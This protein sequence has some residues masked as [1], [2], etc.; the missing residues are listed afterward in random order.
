MSDWDEAGRYGWDVIQALYDADQVEEAFEAARE[1]EF[2][3]WAAYLSFYRQ[4]EAEYLTRRRA[5]IEEL[6]P[7]LSLEWIPE[8]VGD[9]IGRVRELCLYAC[10]RVAERLGWS[11]EEPARIAI[12]ARETDVPW[13]AHPYGYC[14]EKDPYEKICLPLN[15]VFDLQEF[16]HAVA[17]EYAHVIS[18]NLS[19]E[20]APRWLEEAVSVLA[21]RK[22]DA[23]VLAAFKAGR[24][25]WLGPEQLEVAIH[26]DNE[27]RQGLWRAYQQAGLIGRYLASLGEERRLGDLLRAHADENPWRHLGRVLRGRS[28]TDAALRRVYGFG[29]REL[30]RRAREFSASLAS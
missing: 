29:E 7:W 3:W 4:L 21:E 2:D 11:H 22:F 13:A 23:R 1:I 14:A 8:E 24:A 10:E 9:R 18:L 28:R 20:Y 27:D 26:P 17:H 5:R 6:T 16:R 12:L 30:F 19:A 25:P 15:L